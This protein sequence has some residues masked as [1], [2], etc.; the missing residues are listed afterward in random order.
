MG[1][2]PNKRPKQ[3]YKID[4]YSPHFG[5][6]DQYGR[7]RERPFY[8]IDEGPDEDKEIRFQSPKKYQDSPKKH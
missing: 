5:K 8:E 2:L 6:Q 7:G 1:A 4:E 3:G